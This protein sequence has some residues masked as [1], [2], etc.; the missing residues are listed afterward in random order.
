MQSCMRILLICAYSTQALF[1][2]DKKVLHDTSGLLLCERT[3]QWKDTLQ[4]NIGLKVYNLKGF[5]IFNSQFGH[6]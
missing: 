2:T 5:K 4:Q 3:L 1:I 6:L